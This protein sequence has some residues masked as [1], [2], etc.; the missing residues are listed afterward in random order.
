MGLKDIL[1][2]VLHPEPTGTSAPPANPV[3]PDMREWARAWSDAFEKGDLN[4]PQDVHD[5]AG[6]DTYWTNQLRVGPMEQAFSDMMSSDEH[7]IELLAGRDARTVLCAGNGMSS[8]ALSLALHGFRVTALDI[9][10]VP[11]RVMADALRRPDHPASQIPGFRSEDQVFVFGES[12]PLPDD[13]CPRIH[14][15]AP[16]AGGSLTFVV[17]DLMD[18]NICPGPFDAAIERRTLQLLPEAERELALDRLA[19]RLGERGLLVSHLHDGSGRLGRPHHARKWAA[20]RGFLLDVDA[21]SEQ[22]RTAA[23]LARVVLTTG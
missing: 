2:R 9:S 7:L 18:P 17:G 22:R 6:W 5:G 15:K 4:I 11:G 19:S 12:G 21:D 3:N 14:R 10:S 1:R 8:E 20:A 23:R 13:L 16:R